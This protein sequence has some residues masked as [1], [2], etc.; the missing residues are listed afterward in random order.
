MA[1]NCVAALAF[2]LLIFIHLHVMFSHFQ[3]E[4]DIKLC[5]ELRFRSQETLNAISVDLYQLSAA[6]CSVWIIPVDFKWPAQPSRYKLRYCKSPIAYYSN[7]E[8]SFNAIV[9]ISHILV[10][11]G[12]IQLNPG[13]VG[14]HLQTNVFG[15]HG[16]HHD[17][18][19]KVQVHQRIVYTDKY[20]KDLSSK[21]TVVLGNDFQHHLQLIGIYISNIRRRYRGRRAGQNVQ[22]R[23][24]HSRLLQ[25]QAI[26]SGSHVNYQPIAVISR[27]RR[28]NVNSESTNHDGFWPGCCGLSATNNNRLGQTVMMTGLS[29][30]HTEG[31]QQLQ[32]SGTVGELFPRGLKKATKLVDRSALINLSICRSHCKQSVTFPTIFVLNPT[33]L[34]KPHAFD[35]LKCDME[36]FAVDIAVICESW[37]KPKHNSCLFSVPEFQLFRLDRIGRAGGGVCI[38]VKSCLPCKLY[39]FH[40]NRSINPFFELMWLHV[41]INDI[42]E[43][44]ICA[45]Y[46]P[47][48]PKYDS[49]DL[50]DTIADDLEEI[51][52]C[53][54]NAAIVITGDLNSLNTDYFVCDCGLSLINDAVTHGNRILDKCL[55]SRSDVYVCQTVMSCIKTKHKALLISDSNLPP[56]HRKNQNKVHHIC[57]DIREPYLQELRMQLGGYNWKPLL[58]ENNMQLL[59]D[60]FLKVLQWF[61]DTCIPKKSVTI[62]HNASRFIS[63]LVHLLL[64]RRNRL[65]RKGKLDLASLLSEKIG[66]II[67]EEKSA[68]LSSVNTHNTKDL[69]SAVDRAGGNSTIRDISSYGPPFDN[70]DEMNGF[71]ATI[72][73]DPNY[74][75]QHVLSYIK[76]D[77]VE[78]GISH[79]NTVQVLRALQSVHR[80]AQGSDPI[81]FW[82]YKECCVELTEIVTRIFNL[83]LSSSSIPSSWKHSIVTPI[84]KVHPPRGFE[85]LRPISVTP[86][87]SRVFEKLFVRYL[88]YPSLPKTPL[89]DQFAFRPTGSTTAA[90][91]HLFHN[92]TSSLENT[93]YV[94]C[95]LI[96]FSRAFDSVCHSI[97]LEKLTSYGCPQI[98]I[99]WLANFLTDRTQSVVSRYGQSIKLAIT[100]SIIQG[101]GIGP[102]AFIAMI[103]DL[104]PIHK[105][106]KLCKYADDL[107][108]LIPGTALGLLHASEEME[109]IWLWAKRNRLTINSSKSKEIILHKN[110]CKSFVLPSA[111]CNIEQLNKVKLLGVWFTNHMTFSVHVDHVL[112]TISQRMYLLNRLKRQGLDSFGLQVVFN[113]V[114]ISKLTYA[115]QAFSGF[116]SSSDLSRLQSVLNKAHKFKLMDSKYDIRVLFKEYDVN[117]FR[118]ILSNNDHCLHQ[119]LPPERL[120]HGRF[121]RSRGHNCTLPTVS[122]SLHKSSF[123]NRCLFGF[124]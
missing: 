10:L 76:H 8:A 45:C 98:V 7:S 14:H 123:M 80:T 124:I 35:Q 118:Q 1:P 107:T 104:Q 102:T 87:L 66:R 5:R 99:S 111:I 16:H 31:S 100:C 59:Y 79:F 68:F 122:T 47:P 4:I 119:L 22:L 71:F 33:S 121:L 93:N 73:S 69:W 53:N 56:P 117:L 44:I 116:L 97:L 48:K 57:Y 74:D 101:S 42:N 63:P 84:P 51:T 3:C 115:C 70:L 82:V 86:I 90:L 113:A 15:N 43:M 64:R 40:R 65:M 91:V 24:A 96:D 28:A 103:A 46:H 77:S 50:L 27:P 83:S 32:C 67:S 75:K 37:L 120:S 26:P 92:I 17:V 13:P 55:V 88:F 12:D 2:S 19:Q 21:T 41:Q 62:S 94:R 20:L 72:A 105:T 49:Q 38:Y 39:E 30:T 85:D 18:V 60:D 81:P 36:S 54:P 34:A 58:Q 29:H 6:F 95:F 106:T 109:N 110:R 25:G 61:M 23:A 89:L 9:D 108:A 11:S 52:I 78:F 112:S 114:I